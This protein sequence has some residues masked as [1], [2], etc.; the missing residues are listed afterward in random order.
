MAYLGNTPELYNFVAGADRFSGDSSTTVF[1]LTRRVTSANDVI[2]YVENVPQDPFSAYT[3]TANTVSGTADVTFTSAPPTNAN[4]IVIN[5]RATQIV[6]YNRVTAS[7]IEADAITTPKI[8][9]GSVTAAKLASG[10]ALPSQT[11]NATFYL[12][13]DGTNALFKAQTA[14][15]IA[16]TQITGLV[17]S[18]QIANVANT[19]ITGTVLVSQGGTGQSSFTAGQVLIG[20]TAS[21]GLDKTTITPGNGISIANGNGSITITT[22]NGFNGFGAR[23]VSNS[24]PVGGSDG[25]IWYQVS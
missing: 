10:A 3:V 11:G 25:D 8:A 21:G 15:T 23:T 7:V 12:T 16:N 22:A 20:N 14:L 6:S 17:T 1:T 13:T 18:S 24:A 5:Y 9:D 19:K 4:N 2:A